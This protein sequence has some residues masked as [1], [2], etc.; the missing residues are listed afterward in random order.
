MAKRSWG[1]YKEYINVKINLYVCLELYRVFRT[2][3]ELNVEA[4]LVKN[5]E[6][7]KGRPTYKKLQEVWEFSCNDNYR[8]FDRILIS[9]G[10]SRFT[11]DE[12]KRIANIVGIE[13]EYFVGGK[14]KVIQVPG[15]S[16]EDWNYFFNE[17]YDNKIPNCNSYR[18]KK[19]IV[20]KVKKQIFELAVSNIEINY[21]TTEP[22][23][24]INYFYKTGK[25]YKQISRI[26]SIK[27]YIDELNKITVEEWET[28]EALW[29]TASSVLQEKLDVIHS[30]MILKKYRKS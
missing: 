3:R 18:I 9:N 10:N 6:N 22:I 27:N 13:E 1:N 4:F 21:A 25:T 5:G 7:T 8:K 2:R 19:E 14:N 12:A 26:D 20:D 24:R 17:R 16:E 11:K 29:D 28:C 15:I 23:Y 30:L